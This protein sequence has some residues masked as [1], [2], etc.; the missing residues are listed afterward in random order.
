M[1]DVSLQSLLTQ[2]KVV[3]SQ[4][5]EANEKAAK[6]AVANA[7]VLSAVCAQSLNKDVCTIFTAQTAIDMEVKALYSEVEKAQI[8][9]EQWMGLFVVMNDQLKELGDVSNW[10][11]HMAQ[12]MD[13][14]VTCVEALS[15]AAK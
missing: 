2:H 4:L 15:A 5:Q 1:S 6:Q 3:V 12:D 13:D 7:E 8:N 11:T 9:I 10:A 14:I